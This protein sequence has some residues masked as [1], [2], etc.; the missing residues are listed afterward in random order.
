MSNKL[1]FGMLGTGFWARF[2][3][4]GWLETGGARCV[5][6]YNRTRSKADAFATEFGIPAVYDDP[7][8][9]MAAEELDF[10]DIVAG[11]EAH[12]PLVSLAA[13]R[14]LP[15][16]C[17]KPLAPSLAAAE[18]MVAVCRAAR[19]PLYVN[20][21]WRWQTPIRALAHALAEG[22]AGSPFRARIEMVTGYPVFANQPF[23]KDVEQFILADLGSHILDVS[24]F[25]FGESVSIY[26]QHR[27][28][29]PSVKGESVATVIMRTDRDVTVV[30]ELAYAE[31]Y[32][33]RDSFPETSIFV[34]AE[35]GSLEVAPGYW[36][37]E[38]TARGT[39]S[40]RCRPPH[41]PWADPAYDLVHASIVPCQANLLAGLRGDA[42]AETTGEDN[43]QT[44]RLV[45]AAYA[46]AAS[47]VVLR[48]DVD[49]YWS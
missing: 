14:G 36:L 7:G 37:R 19:A 17:Q 2:Q 22:A 44:V 9:L 20:E 31:N 33:E 24:R 29:Q 16:V 13:E 30:C 48:K 40:R 26:C 21:N 5:A 11:V 41:Y 46:S 39:L 42:V 35:R 12:E 27:R 8:E 43:L 10:V 47:D 25:L 18:R 15:V 34:E 3:L 4:N 49:G 38:T 23:L 1:R 32:L 6:V 28:V 45:Y